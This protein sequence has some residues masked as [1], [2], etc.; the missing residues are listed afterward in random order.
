[1]FAHSLISLLILA[2]L[3]TLAQVQTNFLQNVNDITHVYENSMRT[4]TRGHSAQSQYIV[5][6]INIQQ[7]YEKTVYAYTELRYGDNH[8]GLVWK[9]CS[10][11]SSVYPLLILPLLNRKAGLALLSRMHSIK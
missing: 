2:P 3:A 11:S 9:K 8:H 4:F 10:S 6:K 7:A 1:M 5:V